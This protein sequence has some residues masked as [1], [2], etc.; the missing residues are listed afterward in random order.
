[1]RRRELPGSD[2]YN[3]G[4][5]CGCSWWRGLNLEL[6][7]F[8][9]QCGAEEW[10]RI[11][12][13]KGDDEKD[14]MSNGFSSGIDETE[15]RGGGGRRDL[16]HLHSTILASLPSHTHILIFPS[17]I[18]NYEI[19]WLGS[20]HLKLSVNADGVRWAQL[21]NPVSPVDGR[22]HPLC[23]HLRTF[24]SYFH[25]L[26]GLSSMNTSKSD[27]RFLLLWVKTKTTSCTSLWDIVARG[28]H[29]IRNVHLFLDNYVFHFFLKSH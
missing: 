10:P 17:T 19:R 27:S 14:Y 1:M 21:S 2:S 15:W 4:H 26:R 25:E 5:R 3:T 8:L 7:A 9:G 11:R 24:L 16:R 18:A 6:A 23:F 12:K 20:L 28:P 13:V 22:E 29:P